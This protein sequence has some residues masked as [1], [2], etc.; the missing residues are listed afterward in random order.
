FKEEDREIHALTLSVSASTA[1]KIKQ[2]VLRAC[3]EI[4]AIEGAGTG[5]SQVLQLN[6][7]LFPLTRSNLGGED[8]GP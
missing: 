7:Q 4:F 6:I 2:A 8:P 5:K 3:E 1:A